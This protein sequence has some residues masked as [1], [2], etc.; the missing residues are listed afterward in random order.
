[1]DSTIEPYDRLGPYR[2]K[3]RLGQGGMGEV[4]LGIDPD[5]R[6]LAIK[7]IRPDLGEQSDVR[8]RFAREARAAA[9]LKHPN[10]AEL[11]DFGVYDGR[12]FMA[13]EL[14]RG[15][16]LAD[17]R[18]FA[19]EGP[20]LLRVFQRILA[21]LAHAHARGVVHRDLKPENIL[22]GTDANGEPQPKLM[23]FGVVHFRNEDDGDNPENHILGTP[24]YMSPEQAMRLSDV[25]PASD[26]YSVGV[27]LFEFLT[28][29]LP[30][31]SDSAAGM[32]LALMNQTIPPIA[33]L[34]GYESG[35]PWDA[36]MQRILAKDPGERF[37]FAADA[38]RELATMR[39]TGQPSPRH[40]MTK[41]VE[42]GS[43]WITVARSVTAMET[44]H[45]LSAATIP[46]HRIGALLAAQVDGPGWTDILGEVPAFERTPTVVLPTGPAPV[47]MFQLRGVPFEGRKD[48]LEQLTQQL[49]RVVGQALGGGMLIAGALG[50][51]KSRIV[52]QV[53]E[54]VEERAWMQVWSGDYDGRPSGP[55]VG[56]ELAL[57]RGLGVT[58]LT[59]TRLEKRL[60][61]VL[62]RIGIDDA[63][64]RNAVGELC[65]A[66]L[67]QPTNFQAE[68]TRWAVIDRVLD[69]VSEER[70]VLLALDDIHL[71]DGAVLRFL[72]FLA[73]TRNAPR[74]W[75]VLATYRP[76][77]VRGGGSFASGL[78]RLDDIPREFLSRVTLE[79]L[80]LRP[81][82][83][84]VSST[85]PMPQELVD[86][87]AMR[88][89]GNPLFALEL[90]RH[91]V[92]TGMLNGVDEAPV[93]QT[94]LRDLPDAIGSILLKRLEQS[95]DSPDQMATWE[96]LAFLGLRFPIKLARS[97]ELTR[98]DGATVDIEGSITAGLV[99]GMLLLDDDDQI[100]RFDSALLRQ[101]L[102]DRVTGRGQVETHEYSA[103]LAKLRGFG[104]EADE[105]MLDIARHFDRAQKPDQ[106]LKYYS[107]AA[108]FASERHRTVAA[109][110]A[111]RRMEAMVDAGGAGGDDARIEALIGQAMSY[112]RMGAFDEAEQSALL[113][114][115]IAKLSRKPNPATATRVL[116]ISARKK[117]DLRQA[118]S[119]FEVAK[120]AHQRVGD[121]AGV[122]A[123]LFGLGQLELRDGRAQESEAALRE[124][125]RLYAD[126]GDAH[127]EIGAIREMG[128]TA[129]TTGLYEEALE[130]AED[131]LQRAEG[132]DDR[133]NSAMT[134]ALIGEIMGALGDGRTANELFEQARDELA[135]IGDVHGARLAT[136]SMGAIAR[137]QDLA[138]AARSHLEEAWTAL[139]EMGDRQNAAIAALLLGAVEAEAGQWHSALPKIEEALERDAAE[140]IDDPH[141]VSA[142]VDVARLAIFGGRPDAARELLRVAAW[143]LE[144]MSHGSPL[145][146]RVD[147][148]AYLQEALSEDDVQTVDLSAQD[149]ANMEGLN[150]TISD[151]PGASLGDT[152][153]LTPEAAAKLRAEAADTD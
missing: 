37:A 102:L 4:Y 76:E 2:L 8:M 106:A 6:E 116:A 74:R 137:S 35:L 87:I 120:V 88:A 108:R 61:D 49:D 113:A 72:E 115:R 94:V 16:T 55:E 152:L 64:G 45:E 130:L 42:E 103:A 18:D 85:L 69:R 71:S 144:R 82:Q 58:S 93:A 147:E 41:I 150:E 136:L 22:L 53:R 19:P 3:K 141:F 7:L 66:S 23:D 114:R 79:D 110:E 124:A 60:A 123:A 148:V 151:D 146:D 98:A 125:R 128:R 40:R 99:T 56:L 73:A 31:R 140:R 62:D 36:F 48:V 100:L 92:S 145:Y 67:S 11:H 86:V 28:G 39:L 142:L 143:K 109:L 34:D 80:K 47:Q 153:V 139:S 104:E 126:L 135:A 50:L 91:L 78:A 38:A 129:Y 107:R 133:R 27:M 59:G 15:G 54:L 127:G 33:L 119:L 70:P 138:D 75:F 117:G 9:K 21:A 10:I 68:A 24:A 111:Y 96:R 89:G 112:L 25:M 101:A 97:L 29:E 90:V 46:D 105:Q 52:D 43:V 32:I 95:A 17:W 134:R 13:L 65:G 5:G 63:W 131:A 44:A 12:F 20:A 84:I 83:R 122:A 14:V 57:R 149:I 118:R 132:H 77:Y 30:F 51:G 121:Q 81:L 26:L 1:M